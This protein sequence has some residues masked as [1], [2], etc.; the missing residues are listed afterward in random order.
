MKID[1]IKHLYWRAGFGI[2]PRQ[3]ETIKHKSR[4]EIIEH[5]FYEAKSYRPVEVDHSNFEKLYPQD[6][7]RK[8]GE[9]MR[10]IAELR[11]KLTE[12]NLAWIERLTEHEG[13]FREKMTLFWANHFACRDNHSYFMQNYINTLRAHSLGNFRKLTKAI[14]REAAM[15]K[16][17]NLRQNKRLHPN[18]N[19]AREL[20]ELFMLGA[21]NYTEKDIKESSKAFTGYNHDFFGNFK[22]N[23]RQ[24][25][26]GIK[27]FF[28]RK[29][30]FNGDDIID[31]I[32]L[33]KQCARFICEK[34]YAYFVNPVIDDYN[35]SEMVTQFYPRYDIEDLMRYVFE[36]DWFYQERNIGVKIKSPIELLIGLHNSIPYK[37]KDNRQITVIQYMLGQRLLFPPNVAG[38][39]GDKKW[40]DSNTLLMRLR[41]PSLLLNDGRIL[42][43]G[44]RFN[45]TFVKKYSTSH[46]ELNTSSN[47]NYFEKHHESI[48]IDDLEKYILQSPITEGTKNFL[49]DINRN[50]KKEFYLQLVSI[51]EYQLC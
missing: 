6:I 39:Q 38:W 45:D 3:I 7:F 33:E 5:L 25:D 40:I 14:T 15:I 37:I 46:K 50:S 8:K 4:S 13:V 17:L 12:L 26:Y 43:L 42:N 10:V 35:V 23:Q 36:A 29:G 44:G 18:E 31:I 20:M 48:V 11:P 19:F 28:G 27:I 22:F 49:E 30:D 9:L 34:L 41:L 21:G 2:T 47:W 24:H 51:P 1:H 16:F 32:L